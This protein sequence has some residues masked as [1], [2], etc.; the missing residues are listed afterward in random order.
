MPTLL[1]HSALPHNMLTTSAHLC[2]PIPSVLPLRID[3]LQHAAQAFDEQLAHSGAA[4]TPSHFIVRAVPAVPTSSTPLPSCD[5]CQPMVSG[6]CTS[7]F[8]PA[9]S[10]SGPLRGCH[11][12]AAANGKSWSAAGQAAGLRTI[13]SCEK[14]RARKRCV[15][16]THRDGR[17]P[18]SADAEPEGRLQL[19]SPRR[20]G[21]VRARREATWH[22]G[23]LG[24]RGVD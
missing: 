17:A 4:F 22:E 18:I 20:W 9:G 8:L 13:D 5:G 2:R 24:E 16:E 21:E 15:R 11:T 14:R 12:C 7:D 10:A 19:G 23:A 3:L 1:Q 6:W